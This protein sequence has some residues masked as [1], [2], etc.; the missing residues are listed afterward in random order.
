MKAGLLILKDEQRRTIAWLIVEAYIRED[1]MLASR[2]EQ[3]SFLDPVILI[4]VFKI[5][6][7]T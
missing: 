5:Y 1:L 6:N 3:L 7:E 4:Q 2:I